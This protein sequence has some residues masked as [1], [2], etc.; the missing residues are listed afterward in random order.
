MLKDGV[1]EGARQIRWHDNRYTGYTLQADAY[2]VY[3]S[4]FTDP[5]REVVE[6]GC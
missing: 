6:V 3:D 5:A 2:V 4:F 1:D